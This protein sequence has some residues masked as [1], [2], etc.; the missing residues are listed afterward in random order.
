MESTPDQE[1]TDCQQDDGW[2]E[3]IN[4]DDWGMDGQDDNYVPDVI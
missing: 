2:G 4:A 1:M 3:D